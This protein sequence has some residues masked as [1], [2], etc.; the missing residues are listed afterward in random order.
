MQHIYLDH[1][2]GKTTKAIELANKT[3]AYL[4]CI[5]EEEKRRIREQCKRNPVSFAEL[6]SYGMRGSFVRN[7]V[8]DN[9]DAWLEMKLNILMRDFQGLKIDG[10]T[11]TESPEDVL[12]RVLDRWDIK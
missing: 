12:R 4:I 3:G 5:S 11:Y 2:A 9:F 8:V 6:D 7:V 1:G 10:I